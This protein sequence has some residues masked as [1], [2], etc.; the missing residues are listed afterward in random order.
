MSDGFKILVLLFPLILLITLFFL[1]RKDKLLIRY[2]VIWFLAVLV[3]LIVPLFPNTLVKISNYLGLDTV[4][5]LVFAIMIALLFFITIVLTV[6]ISNQ[7][8]KTNI[9]IQE[10]SII[11][12]K[13]YK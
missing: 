9:L 11:N 8:K 6:I 10:I 2:S 5:N 12:S 13:K 1:I 7:R 3:L 4:H